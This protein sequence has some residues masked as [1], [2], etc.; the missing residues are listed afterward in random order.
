MESHPQAERPVAAPRPAPRRH[1]PPDGVPQRPGYASN[2]PIRMVASAG[3]ARRAAAAAS[4]S[5]YGETPHSL[6]AANQSLPYYLPSSTASTDGDT[7]SNHSR[8]ASGDMRP[9][10]PRKSSRQ[11]IGGAALR[12]PLRS[13]NSGARSEG[14]SDWSAS[15]SEASQRSSGSAAFRTTGAARRV[16]PS[17]GLGAPTFRLP[18]HYGA[19]T[20][21]CCRRTSK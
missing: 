16:P 6:P 13:M 17:G 2:A 12:V 8:S 11:S 18:P 15:A 20:A 9:P 19:R 3:S 7:A 5:S 4:G 21:S 14:R 1:S 10:P